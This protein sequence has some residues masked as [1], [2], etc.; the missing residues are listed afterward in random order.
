MVPEYTEGEFMTLLS[1]RTFLAENAM[2][3]GSVALAWLLQQDSLLG[4]TIDDT[5]TKPHFDLTSKPTSFRPR[6]T[7]TRR[8]G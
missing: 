8:T 3:I 6:A 5:Q 7:R 2:G 1:R 4:S